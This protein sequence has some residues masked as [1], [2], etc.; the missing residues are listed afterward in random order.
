MLTL[1]SACGLVSGHSEIHE[2]SLVDPGVMDTKSDQMNKNE[3]HKVLTNV[4]L[5]N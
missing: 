5:S 1:Q 2:N 3:K 4:Y